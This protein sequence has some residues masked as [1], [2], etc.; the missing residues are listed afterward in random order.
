ML[1]TGRFVS[2]MV[3]V[4]LQ[5][6]STPGLLPQE[7]ANALVDAALQLQMLV[8]PGVRSIMGPTFNPLGGL[9]GQDILTGIQPG[10][11]ADAAAVAAAIKRQQ[12]Q[13]AAD[14]E[15]M[16]SLVRELRKLEAAEGL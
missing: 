16:T 13:R 8:L 1:L 15:Q 2:V 7:P 12:Q 11:G 3:Q 5:V 4:L 9:L 6:S 10:M 14:A